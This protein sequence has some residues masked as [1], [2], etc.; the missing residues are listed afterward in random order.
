MYWHI[1]QNIC[2]NSEVDMQ[3]TRVSV[4]LHSAA[5]LMAQTIWH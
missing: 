1:F 4:M 5:E 3:V 2:K